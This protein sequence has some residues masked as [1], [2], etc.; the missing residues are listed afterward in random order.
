MFLKFDN[1]VDAQNLVRQKCFLKNDR[2][3]VLC[4]VTRALRNWKISV[5]AYQNDLQ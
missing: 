1:R 4:H 3:L 5:K 2:K